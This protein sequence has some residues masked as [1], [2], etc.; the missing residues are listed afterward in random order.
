MSTKNHNIFEG[1][2]S[3]SLNINCLK[4]QINRHIFLDRQQST[5]DMTVDLQAH[6]CLITQSYTLCRLTMTEPL[7]PNK[8]GYA[9]GELPL[10][11]V[12]IVAYVR[13]IHADNIEN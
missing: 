5:S 4:N 6:T 2:R 8:L 9:R 7:V 10:V 12:L 11:G 3:N 1:V 13:G